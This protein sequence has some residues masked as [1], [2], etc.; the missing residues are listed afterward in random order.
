MIF[1][2][3]VCL[4]DHQIELPPMSGKLTTNFCRYCDGGKGNA[5]ILRVPESGRPFVAFSGPVLVGG[6]YHVLESVIT[7]FRVCI[8]ISQHSRVNP[9]GQNPE[10]KRKES[11]RLL[12]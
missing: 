4:L 3:S 1:G 11:L 6:S 7:F 12:R 5:L 2:I 9:T 8:K 10:D